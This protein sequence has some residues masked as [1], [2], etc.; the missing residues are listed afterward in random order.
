MASFEAS[1][2]PCQEAGKPDDCLAGEPQWNSTVRTFALHPTPSKWWEK[3]IDDSWLTSANLTASNYGLSKFML[4]AHA[5]ALA[6][7]EAR[8]GTSVHAWAMR[9]GIVYTSLLEHFKWTTCEAGCISMG[10]PGCIKG[11]CPLTP[12]QA[13]ATLTWLSVNN[14]S[15]L[16]DGGYF[17]LCKPEPYPGT[18]GSMPAVWKFPTDNGAILLPEGWNWT[19]SPPAL[20]DWTVRTVTG[21]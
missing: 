6:E 10:F 16:P 18:P 21:H 1:L 2:L 19:S 20:L 8:L 14:T 7:R 4:V 11:I 15:T 5:K 17:F 13:A 3:L 12:E 9:P